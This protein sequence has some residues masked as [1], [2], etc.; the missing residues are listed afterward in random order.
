M[1]FRGDAGA[2]SAPECA[3]VIPFLTTRR[4][5]LDLSEVDAGL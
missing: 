3:R 5:E 2:S 4:D 1:P